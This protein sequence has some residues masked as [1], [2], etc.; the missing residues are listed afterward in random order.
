MEYLKNVVVQYLSLRDGSQRATLE[1][2]LGTLLQFS[3][4]EKRQ[5]AAANDPLAALGDSWGLGSWADW[6]FGGG[7]GS[8][9]GS[10]SS[11]FA[12]APH[13]G[14]NV[15]GGGDGPLSGYS[16]GVV[17]NIRPRTASMPQPR[18]PDGTSTKGAGA[19]AAQVSQQPKRPPQST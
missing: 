1:R 19:A 12:G 4:A 15:I 8:G 14:S 5:I 11:G 18:T 2:V 16:S 17:K 13:S 10:G 3:P 6:G 9:S 7:S